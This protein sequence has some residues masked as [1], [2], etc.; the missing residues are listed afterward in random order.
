MELILRAIYKSVVLE[1]PEAISM[2]A[3]HCES[4]VFLFYRICNNLDLMIGIAS[5]ASL[6]TE[7]IFAQVSILGKCKPVLIIL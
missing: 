4:E 7:N 3:T 5:M 1:L 6:C 2:T